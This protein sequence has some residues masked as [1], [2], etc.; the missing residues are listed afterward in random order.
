MHPPKQ[1]ERSN[2][3]NRRIKVKQ[4]DRPSQGITHHNGGKQLPQYHIKVH[5]IIQYYAILYNAVYN[6]I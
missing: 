5:N 6:I 2:R 1:L 4:Q 3:R